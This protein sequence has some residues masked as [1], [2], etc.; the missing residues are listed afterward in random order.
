M[1]VTGSTHKRVVSGCEARNG[2]NHWTE[3]VDMWRHHSVYYTQTTELTGYIATAICQYTQTEFEYFHIKYYA[4]NKNGSFVTVNRRYDTDCWRLSQ[5]VLFHKR[6]KR[7]KTQHVPSINRCRLLK[8]CWHQ[9][10]SDCWQ[11]KYQNQHWTTYT[12]LLK[13][14]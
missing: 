4:S 1:F 7:I 10:K 9:Y 8:V 6:E 5:P 3:R 11:S 14:R 2:T 13:L 12:G